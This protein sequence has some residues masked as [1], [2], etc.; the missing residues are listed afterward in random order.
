MDFLV[1]LFYYYST[2]SHFE[3]SELAM[4]SVKAEIK[5]LLFFLILNRLTLCN[6]EQTDF[7]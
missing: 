4:H 3:D 2:N 1:D 7:V 6:Y 5:R